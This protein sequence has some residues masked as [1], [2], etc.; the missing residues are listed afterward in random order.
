[1][2][3][4]EYKPIIHLPETDSELLAE[5]VVETFRASGPG[6]QHV[7]TTDSAIRITHIPTNIVVQCQNQRSQHKNRA[8]AMKML[9]GWKGAVPEI[10][11]SG[12]IDLDNIEEYAEKGVDFISVGSLTSS[13]RSIDLSLLT[14]D[15]L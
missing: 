4:D 13:A 10:E 9:G 5:C 3:S 6:G 7:N 14:G 2:T 1:M 11:V 12:G 8:E 15:G